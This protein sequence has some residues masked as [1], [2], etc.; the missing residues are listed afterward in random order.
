MHCKFLEHGITVGYDHVVKPC[1]VWQVDDQWR[2]RHHVSRVDLVNW[3]THPDLQVTKALMDDDIW[4]TAC[5]RCE[6]MERSG[7][8]DSMRG[9]GNRAYGDFAPGDITLEIRPGSICNFACQT[10]WPEASSRVADFYRRAS[11]IDIN[12]INSGKFDDFDF[13]LPVV[14]RIKNVVLLGGE[15]FFDPGCLRFLSWAQNHLHSTITMFTNG[16]MI[17]WQ[18]LEAYQSRV[19]MVFSLD[20]VGPAAEYIRFGTDWPT[21]LDNFQRARTVS[22]VEVRVNITTS[23]YNY[24]YFHEV[25]DMLLPDWP[26]VVTFGVPGSISTKGIDQRTFDERL[27]PMPWRSP[28]IQRLEQLVSRLGTANIELGQ[29]QNAQGAVQSIIERLRTVEF[30]AKAFAAWRDFAGRMD[31]VKHTHMAVGCPELAELLA[32]QPA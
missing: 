1:C 28:L 20:A 12:N 25:I 2:D 17:D 30:D 21:V 24:F 13:L 26:A 22:N 4:P 11:I 6:L 23:I 9:N 15:P 16:S 8:H 14:D 32:Y 19:I 7:R 18:W 27:V 29:R 3:H 5:N 31:R 10:C